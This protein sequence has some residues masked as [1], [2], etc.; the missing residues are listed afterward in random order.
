MKAIKIAMLMTALVAPAQAQTYV[1]SNAKNAFC[2]WEFKGKTGEE[3]CRILAMGEIGDGDVMEISIDGMVVSFL[4]GP[5]GK[6]VRIG[7]WNGTYTD[8]FRSLEG[9]LAQEIY[10]LSNGY[11]INMVY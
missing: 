7:K 8:K 10:K 3:N 6:K 5:N 9:G 11:T 4:N 2:K 1:E